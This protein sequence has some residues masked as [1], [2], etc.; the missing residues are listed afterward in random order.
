[1]SHF[2]PIAQI[3]CKV[4]RSMHRFHMLPDGGRIVVGFSGGADSMMLLH[5]LH[6][7][8]IPLLAAHI[9][10]GLRGAEADRDEQVVRRFCEKF[11][12]ELRTLHTDVQKRA[13][14]LG[15]GVEE[16]GR[17]VRYD[18]FAQLAENGDRIA[19]A[20]TLSDVCET[21]LFHLA[22]G[23]GLKGLCGIPP[24]R[25]A[26]IRPLI[27]VTRGE[28]LDYCARY[29][30]PYVTDS[31]NLLPEYTRN[32]LRLRAVPVLKEVNPAFEQAVL[33][34]TDQCREDEAYLQ[35]LAQQALLLAKIQGGYR[36]QAFLQMPLPVRSRAILLAI[37]QVK[38]VTPAYAQMEQVQK[39]L[40]AKK[41]NVTIT[42]NIFFCV[43]GDS[44]FI[45]TEKFNKTEWSFSAKLPKI[46]LPDGRNLRLCQEFV[47]NCENHMKFHKNLFSICVDYGTITENAVFR[48][49]RAG[50]AFRPAGR[51]VT[52]SLK[53]LFNEAKI[54][55]CVRDR[56]VILAD[57]DRILW[58]EG[59]GPSEFAQ[60]TEKTRVRLLILL[61]PIDPA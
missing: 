32:R 61:H 41:G 42:G 5:L 4:R 50:D 18:F 21:V 30:L 10:H 45:R 37:R 54:P 15:I 24:V 3:V 35:E 58:V 1:M 8:K 6:Q 47:N 53:K 11:A 43:E 38:N 48:N 57:G 59:F 49:R 19:T 46:Q 40:A 7:M 9:H 2:D 13:N 60:V 29:E 55:L 52:K 23:T 26:V 31:T 36:T 51:G 14:Q 44:V 39:A 56:I 27:A 34:L 22:R 16:C 20:H 28:V 25:G 12:I 17:R 33:R